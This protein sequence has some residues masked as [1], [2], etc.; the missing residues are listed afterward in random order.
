MTIKHFEKLSNNYI[1]L[2]EKGIDF[3]VIIKV[4][5]STNI[6]EFKSHSSILKCR[7]FY[8]QNKL[9]DSLKNINRIMKIDLESHISIQ[10]FEIIIKGSVSL[11]NLV[12][13][14]IF[15]LTLVADEFLL[16]EL[17][18]DLQME[19]IKI[20]NYI[21]VGI[22][23]NPNLPSD[24]ETEH[25]AEIASWIDNNTI[26]YNVKNNLYEIKLLLCGSRGGL[27]VNHFGIY[28]I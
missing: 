18:V 27:T 8:F 12:N 28:A 14:F 4:E 21:K 1:E 24:P 6:K 7:F 13:Q 15:D 19:E 11:E 26:G 10:Q 22:A 25:A 9:K 5:K 16:E 20:W 17:R 23:Q 3:N 2:L